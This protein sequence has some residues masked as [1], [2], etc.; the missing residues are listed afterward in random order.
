MGGIKSFS[1]IILVREPLCEGRGLNN[2]CLI[3]K[4]A[5]CVFVWERGVLSIIKGNHDSNKPNYVEAVNKIAN[6]NENVLGFHCN[7][8]HCV[9]LQILLGYGMAYG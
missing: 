2:A 9:L 7:D 1:H 8:K 3:L 5:C 6:E 4:D